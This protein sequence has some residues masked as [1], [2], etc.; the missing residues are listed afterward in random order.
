M[1]VLKDGSIVDRDVSQEPPVSGREMLVAVDRRVELVERPAAYDLGHEVPHERPSLSLVER[2]KR[3][4]REPDKRIR[5]AP[6]E[7]VNLLHA[8]R[9]AGMVDF[10]HLIPAALDIKNRALAARMK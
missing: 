3:P 6:D 9:L 8:R 10:R 5:P 1:N 2:I 4:C 7:A